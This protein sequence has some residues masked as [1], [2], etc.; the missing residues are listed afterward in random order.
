MQR[1]RIFAKQAR[2]DKGHIQEE[3][4]RCERR[5]D[6]GKKRRTNAEQQGAMF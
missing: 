4:N 2:R 1:R 5:I 3:K 6:E